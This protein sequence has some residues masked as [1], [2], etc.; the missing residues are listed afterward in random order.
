MK[1]CREQVHAALD[2]SNSTTTTA[3]SVA[4][5]A[6]GHVV[7]NEAFGYKDREKGIPATPE[8]CFNIGSVSK[9][10]TALAVM[11]LRDRGKL[12]LDQPLVDPLPT[13]RM[14]SSAFTRVT[15]RHLLS[16]ASGFPGNNMRD[17]GAFTP[18]LGYARNTQNALAASHLKHEPGELAVYCND[19]FTMIEP[20]A[21]AVDGRTFPEFVQQE[22]FDPLDMRSSGYP[23][24]LSADGTYIHPYF[25]GR[26]LSQEMS[27]PFSTGGIFSTPSDLMK[28]AQMLIDQGI[29]KGRRL[30][31]ASAIQEMATDQS[32]RTVIN[33]AAE[34]W[35]WGLGWD[36]VQQAD[37]NA[38][39]LRAW[40]KNGGTFFFSSEFFVLPELRMA[41][42]ITGSGQDYEPLK[43]AEG[44]LLRAAF[45]K[46]AIPELS[47]A[48]SPVPAP[49]HPC[50]WWPKAMVRSHCAVGTE[51]NGW[52]STTAFARAS[53]ATGRPMAVPWCAIG[54]RQWGSVTT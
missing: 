49:S 2:R 32:V 26:T 33:P 34:S 37:M 35:K 28:F 47:G 20:L 11:I 25:Q 50:K 18:Y 27:T 9:V 41:M 4:L 14:L 42:L 51:P 54:S 23:A 38:A 17:N 19:G 10:V 22:I 52:S 1:W 15:V 46:G 39:G 40:R 43:I 48:I 8:T 12:E 16:H 7:W 21:Q 5:L 44:L 45:A 24:K 53:M 29:Y 30:V 31:S 36:S 3:V 6:D 13:F